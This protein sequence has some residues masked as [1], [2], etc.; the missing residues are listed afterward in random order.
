MVQSWRMMN[1]GHPEPE[2]WGVIS[3]AMPEMPETLQQAVNHW[4]DVVLAFSGLSL[5]LGYGA[6]VLALP[7][8]LLP[9]A[10]PE[11]SRPRDGIWS[12]VL[13]TLAPLLLL[14]PFPVFSSGGLGELIATV[15]LA[16]LAAEVGQGR[17]ASLT[18]DQRLALRHLPRWRRAGADLVTA[19]VQAAK[20][21]RRGTARMAKAAWGAVSGPKSPVE[22]PQQGQSAQKPEQQPGRKQWIRPDSSDGAPPADQDGKT[23][24]GAPDV[25]SEAGSSAGPATDRALDGEAAQPTD[26]G[27]PGQGASEAGDDGAKPGEPKPSGGG[28]A[29]SGGHGPEPGESEPAEATQPAQS[30]DGDDGEPGGGTGADAV[31]E[32]AAPEAGEVGAKPWEPEPSGGSAA[33]SGGHGPEPGESEPAEATQPAQ[34]IDGDDGE[35]GGGTG[36][37]AVPEDAAPEAGEVG[38]KPWEPEP[39]GGSAAASGGHGPEPGESEPAEATQSAQSIDGGTDIPEV[40]EADASVQDGG[41]HTPVDVAPGDGPG[42]G[43]SASEAADAGATQE[44]ADTPEA[45]P[46]PVEPAGDG[47]TK[48]VEDGEDV[49]VRSFDEVDE[50]LQNFT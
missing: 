31:P 37:D 34:S 41:N 9:T 8:L 39:S 28:A 43:G 35:P 30:I 38:A 48:S 40:G 22:Q 24:A 46:G 23:G 6:L 10:F 33:A 13:A 50:K 19:V 45:E 18:P 36:A 17:W 12:L 25:A 32:D 3:L 26:G 47:S 42:G 4:L 15:L 5:V 2:L 14:N 11:L 16:R 21:A 27:E 20:S 7:L 49:V 44:V 1:P 29:A